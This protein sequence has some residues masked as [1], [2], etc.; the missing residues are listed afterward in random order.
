MPP[1]WVGLILLAAL[2]VHAL[3]TKVPDLLSEMLYACHVA[4]AL[5]AVGILLGRPEPVA[6]AFVFHVGMGAPA[7]V[8]DIATSGIAQPTSILVHILPLVVGILVVRRHG[9]R[10]WAL[11]GA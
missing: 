8:L 1:R 6:P 9:L 7:L 11:G 2:V 10:P 4:T 3:V 5:M